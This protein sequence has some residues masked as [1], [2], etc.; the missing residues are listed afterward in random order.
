MFCN[1]QPRK[2]LPVYFKHDFIPII[3]NFFLST[4]GGYLN[5]LCLMYGPQ[6]VLEEDQEKAGVIMQLSITVG[7]C[8][9]AAL[10]YSIVAMI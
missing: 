8:F 6:Q 4:S 7:L 3:L 1:Y 2:H 9:G 5:S 10:S